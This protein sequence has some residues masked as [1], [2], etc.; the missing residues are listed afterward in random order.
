MA[1]GASSGMPKVDPF[2]RYAVIPPRR[3]STSTPSS[4]REV[5]TIPASG[6]NVASTPSGETSVTLASPGTSP[7]VPCRTSYPL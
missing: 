5:P 7:S 3:A 6:T 2:P 1:Q 4:V